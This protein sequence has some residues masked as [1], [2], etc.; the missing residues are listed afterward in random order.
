L[1]DLLDKFDPHWI[2]TNAISLDTFQSIVLE[3][4]QETN[5]ADDAYQL[6][7]RRNRGYIEF[8]DFE[9]VIFLSCVFSW[10]QL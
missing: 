4:N 9:R 6:L 2:L 10:I 8:Q 7:D 5:F 3:L 1:R